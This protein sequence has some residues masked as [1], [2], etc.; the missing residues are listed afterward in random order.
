MTNQ[1]NISVEKVRNR[2]LT[3]D[4]F[5]LEETKKLQY[6]CG[7]K[8]VIRYELERSETDFSESVA[9]HSHSMQVIADYFLRIEPGAD[10]LD[11]AL[12]QTM[13]TWHDMDELET[14]DKIS[15]KKTPEDIENEL[16]AWKEAVAKFPEVLQPAIGAAIEDYEHRNSLEAKFVKAIDKF[17]PVFHLFNEQGKQWIQ[18]V[19]LNF[20]VGKQDKVKYIANY[21]IM[22]RFLDVIHDEML[23]KGFFS[24]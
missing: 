21:P 9:E 20:E 22:M 19:N 3:D 17:E 5:V 8:Y 24:S 16:T 7:L 18:S 11:A 2:L 13:I 15:W 23:K 4:G 12:V 1:S 10:K 14:G 6:A